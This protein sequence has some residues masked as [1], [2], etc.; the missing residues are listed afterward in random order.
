MK[1]G[2]LIILRN[3]ELNKP[4]IVCNGLPRGLSS[5]FKDENDFKI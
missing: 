4:G 1:F 5:Q 3:N 2:E